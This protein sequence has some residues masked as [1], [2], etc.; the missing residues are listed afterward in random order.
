MLFWFYH[1]SGARWKRL[2]QRK[3]LRP[4]PTQ[5]LS[6][7]LILL[8]P[9]VGGTGNDHYVDELEYHTFQVIKF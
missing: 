4:F 1:L 2:G 9:L 7:H 5:P 6:L 8:A 3:R